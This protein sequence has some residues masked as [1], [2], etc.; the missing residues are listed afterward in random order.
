MGNVSLI[1][2][3]IDEV[4]D[5]ETFD[6]KDIPTPTDADAPMEYKEPCY[7][8][9]NA[10]IDDDLTDYNDFYSGTIGSF[11]HDCRIM[12][13]SGSGKPLRIEIARWSDKRQ[14]WEDIGIYYPKFCPE[15][16]REIVEYQK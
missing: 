10:R 9:N 3:H 11:S 12:L 1:D 4:F 13:T 7:M 5:C 6:Y 2:G 16:G 14:Q 8:C 15:C